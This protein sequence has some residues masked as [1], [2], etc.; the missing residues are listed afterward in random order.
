[1]DEHKNMHGCVVTVASETCCRGLWLSVQYC[2]RWCKLVLPFWP[3]NKM[4]VH[5]V[6]S[7]DV[8][9]KGEVQNYTFDQQSYGNYLLVCWGVCIGWFSAER[10]SMIMAHYIHMLK[11]LQCILCEKCLMKTVIL[12]YDSAW[13]HTMSDIGGSHKECLKVLL[14]PLHSPRLATLESWKVTW[15]AN[16]MRMICIPGSHPYLFGGAGMDFYRSRIFKVVQHWQK[17]M[18][19]LEIL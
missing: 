1:M 3:K 19:C 2:D 17:C 4:T 7:H 13:L 14:H 10:V 8:S 15:Q 6:A 16:T 9:R 5:G 11:E 12:Q 18:E